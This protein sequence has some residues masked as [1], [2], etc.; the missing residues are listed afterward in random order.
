VFSD[1]LSRAEQVADCSTLLIQAIRKK[2]PPQKSPEMYER[3]S[4]VNTQYFYWR[5][6]TW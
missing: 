3:H 1:W 5:Y 2:I 6:W 4:T